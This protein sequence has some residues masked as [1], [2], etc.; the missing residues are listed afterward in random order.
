MAKYK[1]ITEYEIRASVK[2]IYPYL[3]TASGLQEWL[4]DEVN[5]NPDK[6][7]TITWDD[8]DTYLAK[9]LSNRNNHHIKYEFTNTKDEEGNC[10]T[11]EFKVDYNEL[12]QSSFLRI[13]D[14]SEMDDEEELKELWG[15]L[16]EH[17]REI[18]G[19]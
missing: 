17:L 16:V 8:G 9:V 7:L 18:L 3:A 10:N 12:T 15:H 2:M 4:A 5:I 14:V 19:A 13:F 11:L 1:Y 6:T